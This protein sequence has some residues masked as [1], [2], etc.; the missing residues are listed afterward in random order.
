LEE[1]RTTLKLRDVEITR[2]TRELV[3]EAVSFEELRNT[4]EEKDATILVLQQ[5][6][7][8]ARAALEMEKK[9]VEGKLPLLIF[10]LLLGFVEIRSRLILLFCF[11]A[12]RWLSGRQRH[13]QRRSRRPTTPLSRN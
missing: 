5:T 13:R 4:G 2:L 10:H 8:T 7:E 9:Q 12:Y 11:Q 6:T 1:A 3:Q